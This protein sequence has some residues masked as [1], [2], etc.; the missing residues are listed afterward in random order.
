MPRC[1]KAYASGATS[2]AITAASR[3]AF[4]MALHVVA[5]HR[6]VRRART[7]RVGQRVRVQLGHHPDA[8]LV[9][10]PA[11]PASGPCPS[12]RN[13]RLRAGRSQ[14]VDQPRELPR[15]G[16]GLRAHAGHD[17]ADDPEAVALREVPEALVV[18]DEHPLRRGDRR[19]LGRGSRGRA[20]GAACCRRRHSR[21]TPT[22]RRG[23]MPTR[24][25]RMFST[26]RTTSRGARKKCGSGSS[27]DILGVRPADA[28]TTVAARPRSQGASRGKAS[29]PAPFTMSSRL[30]CTVETSRGVGS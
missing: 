28:S 9:A 20:P 8:R 5:H 29:M 24:P 2:Q 26:Y 21:H 27:P 23:R 4:T 17:R 22:R 6:D 19:A 13:T 14:R 11:G 10:R 16:R 1:M 30:S 25:S 12:S 3:S 18:G 7:R 15:R